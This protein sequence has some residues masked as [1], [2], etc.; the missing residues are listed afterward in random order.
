M[1][2]LYGVKTVEKVS[3]KST[4]QRKDVKDVIE[5]YKSPTIL[6]K[7]WLD[8]PIFASTN[9]ITQDKAVKRFV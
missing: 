6:V 3:W 7:K 1:I 5:K 2:F 4:L 9:P 8:N